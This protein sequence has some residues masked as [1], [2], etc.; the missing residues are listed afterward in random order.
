MRSV[1][2]AAV[3]VC[4]FAATA[5]RAADPTADPTADCPGHPDAL[6]TSRTIVV[7]PTEHA[8]LGTMQYRETLPL[9]DKEV[10]L[11]FDDGPLPPYTHRILDILAAQCVKAT[12]FIVGRQVQAFPDLVRR[13][14]NEG[15]TIGTHT[16]NH[17]FRFDRLPIYRAIQEVE[18][19]IA[20]T[21]AALGDDR[22]LAPFFR[23]PGLR[24]SSEAESYLGAHGVMVWSTDFLADDGRHI[25]AK[26]VMQ[27]ALDRLER[28]GK[29]VLLL[30]DIQP[31][32]ALAL[33]DILKALKARGYRIVHVVPAT[34]D[35]PKTVT[36]P[37]QWVL[38]APAKH[39]W[40]RVV[41]GAAAESAAVSTAALNNAEPK[42]AAEAKAADAQIAGA[43]VG[44]ADAEA[45]MADVEAAEP[46]PAEAQAPAT[47]P[48][49]VKAVQVGSRRIKVAR[50]GL[51]VPSPDSF[52]WPRLYQAGALVPVRLMRIKLARHLGYQT[53]PVVEARWP[54][55]LGHPMTTSEIALPA[56]NPRSFVI[57]RGHGPQVPIPLVSQTGMT[58]PIPDQRAGIAFS[59]VGL[60]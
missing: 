41:E 28:K 17:P 50:A 5:A 22:A 11:T 30:H 49:E 48:V 15:H 6:G 7:D 37:Q 39:A 9:Q 12:F 14:Y 34:P 10:V 43:K 33:P 25:S 47:K 35:R 21:K 46:E 38:R 32:T 27:R 44:G 23:V 57:P 56:P 60:P 52:G 2:A 45:K 8:R 40:P 51:P 24:T 16:Q 58:K 42:A 36:E 31:A 18:D 55:A 20:S 4:A 26:Q 54:A 29:G 13:A 19:G 59:S 53:V 1:L 3:V